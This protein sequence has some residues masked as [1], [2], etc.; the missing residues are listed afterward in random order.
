VIKKTRV[1]EQLADWVNQRVALPHD[2]TINVTDKPPPGVDDPVTSPDG[3]TITV[4]AFS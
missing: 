4:P 2:L 3:R 1:F